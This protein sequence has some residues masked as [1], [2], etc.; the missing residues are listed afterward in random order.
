MSKIPLISVVMT[1]YNHSSY[2]AEAIQSVLNQSFTDFELII[3]D[4]ASQDDSA[5][6]IKSF[7]D[8]RI[9]F[10]KNNIN[11][12][13]IPSVNKGIEISRGK[14]IAHINS[15]DRFSCVDKLKKQLLY[16]E[17]NDSYA[18]V[19]TRVKVLDD[20]GLN[21]LEK[22]HFYYSIFDKERNKN[23]FK[24]LENFFHNGNS[25]CYPSVMIRRKVY[26]ELGYFNLAYTV[27]LDLEMWIRI[28][29]KYEIHIIDEYLTE[30]RVGNNSQS[31]A[32]DLL[33]VSKYE[34]QRVLE[35]FLEIENISE[36][37]VIFDR[38]V[39]NIFHSKMEEKLFIQLSIIEIAMT[40]GYEVFALNS[41]F[42]IFNN[43]KSRHVVENFSYLKFNSFKKSHL[44]NA[45]CNDSSLRK[46]LKD[47]IRKESFIYKIMNPFWSVRRFFLKKAIKII[48]N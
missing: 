44:N 18:A 10:I 32:A 12:G 2:I 26:E 24:W 37:E 41:L 34:Y 39:N 13:M 31:C 38:K 14:Y 19:F 30:F 22:N 40:L 45:Y 16:L 15:D 1:S 7:K 20:N 46:E 33:P 9:I 27:M 6:V 21:L 36:F 23:R 5:L 4:D 43:P 29:F 11:Q 35:L 28:C 8:Q 42:K 25:L 17:A 48:L 3:I 47:M